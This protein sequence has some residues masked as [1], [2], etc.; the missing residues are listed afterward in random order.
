MHLLLT[1]A[2][3]Q[4][5]H[6]EDSAA[7]DTGTNA[8]DADTGTDA[9]TDVATDDCADGLDGDGDGWVDA[10]DPDCAD[11]SAEAGYGSADCNDGV[12]DDGDGVADAA[13]PECATALTA[14]EEA[15]AAPVGEPSIADVGIRLLGD[16]PNRYA[17][18]AVSDAGD[19]D[20]DGYDDILV[21]AGDYSATWLVRGPMLADE[22]LADA[23]ARI[24][25]STD[26]DGAIYA[27]AAAGDL[28]GDG[29]G[30]VVLGSYGAWGGSGRVYVLPGPILGEI[31]MSAGVI[32]TGE[33]GDYAGISLDGGDDLTGDGVPDVVVGAFGTSGSRGRVYVLAGPA[34]TG[35][36][37]QDQHAVIEGENSQDYAGGGVAVVGDVNG[38]GDD[39]LIVGAQG[40]GSADRGRVYLLHGPAASG[41]L[42]DAD[43][44]WDGE[45]EGDQL[46]RSVDGPG[47]VDGDGYA[48]LLT[49]TLQNNEPGAG[50]GSAYLVRGGALSGAGSIADAD[51][52][53]RGE[54]SGDRVGY[55]VSAGGDIDGDGTPDLL[56]SA[57]LSAV[58]GPEAGAVYVVYGPV[59]AG[60]YD[61]AT[62]DARIVG[63][64]EGDSIGELLSRAGDTD[65]KSVV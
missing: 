64:N 24:T 14:S 38:D 48:E 37:L 5:V 15:H 7:R 17:G 59:A 11:G 32:Y 10:D 39:D 35:G 20:A 28:D 56:F 8:A 49:G 57:F 30:D 21:A 60:E 6:F 25:A 1:L 45:V 9:D 40:G 27:T 61:L 42:A 34:S 23:D 19:V 63:E 53:F 22:S 44:T 51:T 50:A 16:A 62:A 47:D 43:A 18:F 41:G 33:A 52:I 12:D 31:D 26:Y 58:G 4:K 65:R 54:S 29:L 55:P 2:C 46:G 13:D 36:D 3:I